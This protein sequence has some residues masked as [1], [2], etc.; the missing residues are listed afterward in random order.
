[1]A[2]TPSDRELLEAFVKVEEV[3]RSGSVKH[4]NGRNIFEPK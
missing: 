3:G 2:N 4:V 1:V